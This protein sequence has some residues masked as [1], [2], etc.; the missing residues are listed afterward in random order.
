MTMQTNTAELIALLKAKLAH[1]ENVTAKGVDSVAIFE[2]AEFSGLAK[3]F[4]Y[5]AEEELA[6]RQA[7]ESRA[8]QARIEAA[9]T[10]DA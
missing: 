7:D 5:V 10:E 3:K 6:E 1:V 2:I 4:H 9:I 8:R